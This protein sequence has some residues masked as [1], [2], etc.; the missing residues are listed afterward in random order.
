MRP[1]IYTSILCLTHRCNLNCVYCFENKDG[2]HEL[3]FDTA[4]SL[5]VDYPRLDLLLSTEE[6]LQVV[7]DFTLDR[8]GVGIAIHV[9]ARIHKVPSN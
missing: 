1:K 2:N 6:V 5:N 7:N 9:I 3:T 8:K 4:M